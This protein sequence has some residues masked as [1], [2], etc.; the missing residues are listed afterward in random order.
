MLRAIVLIALLALSLGGTAEAASIRQQQSFAAWHIQDLCA[1]DAFRKF[2]D[3]TVEGNAARD[4]YIRSCEVR[5]HL[6][7]RADLHDSPIRR[8]PDSQAE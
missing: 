4:R 5:H 6:P 1:R 7:P 8:I 3:Y 2:P